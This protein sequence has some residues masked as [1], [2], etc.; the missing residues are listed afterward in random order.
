MILINALNAFPKL[1]MDV[2][3]PSEKEKT[4][5]E[6]GTIWKHEKL[7]RSFFSPIFVQSFILTFLAEW[8]D[9]SQLTTIILAAKNVSRDD[10][11][12][13]SDDCLKSTKNLDIISPNSRS[14]FFMLIIDFTGCPIPILGILAKNC[15]LRST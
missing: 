15:N 5:V 8:G 10:V 1:M 2:K 7:F 11:D 14:I 13:D 3:T 12:D 9:R 6:L 4:G